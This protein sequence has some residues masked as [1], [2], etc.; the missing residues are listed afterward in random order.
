MQPQAPNPQQKI[1]GGMSLMSH[2]DELR[3]RLL[4][5]MVVLVVILLAT[6]GLRREILDLIRAPV[7]GPLQKY[8][9]QNQQ[10]QA[11]NTGGFADLD[12]Y[13]CNCTRSASEFQL[14]PMVQTEA[15]AQEVRPDFPNASTPIKTL[16]EKATSLS[17]NSAE[18]WMGF[19]KDSFRD[20]LAFYYTMVGKDQQAAKLLGEPG[21]AKVANQQ[22]YKMQGGDVLELNCHCTRDRS[23]PKEGAMVYIGLPEL[24]FAQM[25]VAIYSAVFLSF[26]YLLI[27]L[28]GFVGPALYKDEKMV[29][30]GFG[31]STLVFFTGG[32][33]FG[34]FVVFPFGFD[35]FLSLSQP[36]EI[37]PSLSIGDYLDFTIKLFLAFGMI[38]ELPVAVFILSRL[39]IITPKLMITQ[40]KPAMVII[41]ILSAILTPPDPFT[42]MLMAGPLAGLYVFSILVCFFG[43]NKKKAALRS[44]GINPEEFD[45]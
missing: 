37:M 30:W 23:K 41:M 44:Q 24:F 8:S 28:W 40:A 7:E 9:Q 32:A 36:G 16:E 6:Y 25:K 33:C 29:Y 34:Y 11:Q 2:L 12:D 27:E 17:E 18:D 38:F 1:D 26:P 22:H 4:R 31:V 19:L 13:S 10:K 39:G 5:Y 3:V 43:L 35:F 21:E 45:D 15:L 14:S 20:F 42:M